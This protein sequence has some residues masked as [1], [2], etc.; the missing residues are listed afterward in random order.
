MDTQTRTIQIKCKGWHTCY[1]TGDL[2]TGD[3]YPM[4][5]DVRTVLG[6][7]WDAGRKGWVV[8]LDKLAAKLG[9]GNS[10]IMHL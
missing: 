9:S 1:L 8:D 2:L 6:G 4:A 7:K 5:A 10:F 3:T